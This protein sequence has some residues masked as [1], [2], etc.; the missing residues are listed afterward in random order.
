LQEGGVPWM[1]HIAMYEVTTT[2]HGH[3]RLCLN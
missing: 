2:W 1:H 3:D